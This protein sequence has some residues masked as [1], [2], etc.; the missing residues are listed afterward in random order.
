MNTYTVE[1]IIYGKAM[2]T[3]VM[4]LS[5]ERAKEII[6]NKI[7]FHNVVEKIKPE[8]TKPNNASESFIKD[9]FNF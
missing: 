6:R 5:A 1:F 7:I 2:R 8:P 4:A 3:D 9:F